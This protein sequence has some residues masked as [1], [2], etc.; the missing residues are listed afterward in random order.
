MNETLKAAGHIGAELGAAMAE[1]EALRE[2]VKVLQS[3]ANSWQSGYDKGRIDGARHRKSEVE[4]LREELRKIANLPMDRCSTENDY[5]L[6]GAKAM[7]LAAISKQPEPTDT[8]TAVDMATAAAQGFR[9]GQ[10]AVEPA[11]VQDEREY[12]H[13]A[14][15]KLAADR[16]RVSAAGAGPLS[17]YSVR[18]GDG[19]QELYR[20]SKSDCE[21]VARKLAGAFLDGGFAAF[22]LYA[23]PIA[24]TAPQG[25]RIVF[26]GPPGPEAG[27]FV[28][29]ENAAGSSVNSGEWRERADGLWELVLNGPAPQPEQSGLDPHA[30][31]QQVREALDRQACPNA[32]M[33]IAYEATVAALSA[34]PSPA[35][36][37]K[38]E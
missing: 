18:A 22:E 36:D 32:W 24:Q 26:D 20:G 13:E 23:A 35:M 28:E 37:A 8:F 9:D 5:R 14:M 33:V 12:P 31:A 2:Q 34:T 10:A 7:A 1:I 16:Y 27:R 3:D 15:D 11:P 30:I 25:L 21:H 17:R 29:V 38:E 6:S 4:R 19:E